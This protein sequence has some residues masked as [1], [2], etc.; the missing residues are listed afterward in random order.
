MHL[1][2]LSTLTCPRKSCCTANAGFTV[3]VTEQA[4]DD[5]PEY[6]I[7]IVRKLANRMDYPMLYGM[8]GHAVEGLPPDLPDDYDSNQEF[9]TV[10]A[11]TLYGFIVLEGSITCNSCGLIFP[12]TEGIPRMRL[13][14]KDADDPIRN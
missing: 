14:E 10:L 8:V 9:L 6:N 12:I 2:L 3:D 1:F 13:P 4:E 11:Y 7:D 5:A